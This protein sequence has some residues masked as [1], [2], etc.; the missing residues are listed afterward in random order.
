MYLFAS[1]I[2]ILYYYFFYYRI[3]EEIIIKEK[4]LAEIQSKVTELNQKSIIDKKL[5][6]KLIKENEELKN[7]S[8]SN[9]N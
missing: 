4:L 5:N 7:E 1:I 9:N 8:E 6:S 2:T 3:K